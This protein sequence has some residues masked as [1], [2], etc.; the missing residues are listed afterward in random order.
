[1]EQLAAGG[2]PLGIM[3]EADFREGHTKLSPGDV[4]VIYLGRRF[5]G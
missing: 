2:L 1:M 4:L 5:R 3:A